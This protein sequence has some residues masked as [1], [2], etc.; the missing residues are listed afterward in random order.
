MCR[1]RRGGWIRGGGG[2]AS[3]GGRGGSGALNE[4]KRD[5]WI[6]RSQHPDS[7]RRIPMTD[8]NG[9]SILGADGKPIMTRECTYTGPNGSNVVVQDHSAGHQFGEGGVGDQGSHF[10]VR[11]PENTRTGSVPGQ[12][13]TTHGE[14]MTTTNWIDLIL[15]AASV[16]AIFGPHVPT[17]DGIDLHEVTLHRDGPRVQLRFD[18][19]EFPEQP[20]KKWVSGGFN[21]VQLRLMALGVQTFSIEGLQSNMKLNLRLEEDGSMRRISASNGLVRLDLTADAVVIEGISAYR[22]EL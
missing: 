5:S 1:T 22:D 20:P 2:E 19:R 7:V 13:I 17:L 6:P 8:R 18:L 4:A 12:K 11:P 3:E 14:R 21:R 9:K 10:N 15:E 16:T